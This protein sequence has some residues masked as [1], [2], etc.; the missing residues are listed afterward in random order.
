MK[1]SRLRW[2]GK[3]RA[4]AVQALVESRCSMWSSQWSPGADVPTL[5]ALS[6]KGGKAFSYDPRWHAS[7][8]VAGACF[9]LAS[10]AQFR[11]LGCRL[12]K[13]KV[14]DNNGIA[15]RIGK[16]AISHL[17]ATVVGEIEK[18]DLISLPG[19]PPEI[20]INYGAAGFLMRLQGFEA[21]MHL[22]ADLVDALVPPESPS[23]VILQSR[24]SSVMPIQTTFVTT[25]DLGTTSIASSV[26]LRVGDIVRTS[27]PT[28][29][30]LHIHSASKRH[31]VTGDLAEINGKRALR[32]T[33]SKQMKYRQ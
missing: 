15:L 4:E 19:M 8:G 23:P 33:H 5:T 24:M 13:V 31:A 17:A 30:L 26:S 10:D 27:I 1:A 11:N 3:T 9:F 18:E 6:T 7:R 2:V 16:K 20:G 29:A 12:L 22:D 28:S 25:L 21:E 14:N 32:V